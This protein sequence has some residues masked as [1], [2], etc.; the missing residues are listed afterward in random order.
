MQGKEVGTIRVRKGSC[1]N[2]A[3]ANDIHFAALVDSNHTSVMLNNW[4][5]TIRNGDAKK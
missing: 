1:N 3:N 2:S 4:H 5:A